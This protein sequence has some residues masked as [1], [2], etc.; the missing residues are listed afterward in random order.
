MVQLLQRFV[1]DEPIAGDREPAKMLQTFQML[2]AVVHQRRIDRVDLR[3]PHVRSGGRQF[4]VVLEE[5]V[6]MGQFERGTVSQQPL[7]AG[8]I[9]TDFFDSL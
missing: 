3:Y 1:G 6:G 5:G 7:H 8:R 2:E 4:V 9:R